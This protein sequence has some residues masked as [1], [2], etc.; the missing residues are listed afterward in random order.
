MVRYDPA[1]TVEL[2]SATHGDDELWESDE[3]LFKIDANTRN[4]DIP[5]DFRK[6]GVAVQGDDR[7]EIVYFSIDRYFD[8]TD[9]YHKEIFI[10]W[11]PP[12]RDGKPVSDGTMLSPVINKS[13]YY[14][15][16][17]VVFGWPIVKEMTEYAGDMEFSVRF[18]DRDEKD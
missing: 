9:L 17:H 13:L 3:H 6:N 8:L 12:G 15:P 4:I 10:L 5:E 11:N 18:Y 1:F 16:N 2:S 7:A 14:K